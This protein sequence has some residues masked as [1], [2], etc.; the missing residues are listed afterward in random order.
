M[1]SDILRSR[2]TSVSI[3]RSLKMVDCSNMWVWPGDRARRFVRIWG[4]QTLTVSARVFHSNLQF[5]GRTAAVRC[6]WSII[7]GIDVISGDLLVSFVL[8]VCGACFVAKKICPFVSRHHIPS[9]AASQ[10]RGCRNAGPLFYHW[11][12]CRQQLNLWQTFRHRVHGKST[13][14]RQYHKQQS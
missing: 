14:R 4:K 5:P 11:W 6:R 1:S 12:A 3:F 9:A 8:I 7:L 10:V 13:R 2:T